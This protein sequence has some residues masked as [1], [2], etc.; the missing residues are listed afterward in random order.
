VQ[1]ALN[2]LETN[3]DTQVSMSRVTGAIHALAMNPANPKLSD[4]RVRQ[5]LALAVDRQTM[6]DVVYGGYARA[7]GMIP[8][9][10]PFESEPS[11]DQLGS[12]M[13]FDP[14][15]AKKLLSAA[16]AENLQLEDRH[17]NY[18][19]S[20]GSVGEVLVQQFADIGVT[21][22]L[23]ADDYNTYTTLW[24]GGNLEEVTH[25][26]WGGG[27][28]TADG[29]TYVQVHT[30]SPGNRWKI[31]DSV[32]DDLTLRQRVEHDPDARRELL[33]QIY[34]HDMDK[35]YRLPMPAGH[36]IESMQP[37]VRRMRFGGAVGTSA[38]N[39]DWAEQLNSIWLDK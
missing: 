28:P 18:L 11:G 37:W 9:V 3:P 25:T 19:A 39:H 2:L 22:D 34:D 5:G 15:E 38:G 36:S 17:F 20:W 7:H 24:V 14:D 29:Y 16:G 30:E 6:I 35:M 12:Y 8:W 31:S 33:K 13:H 23:V 1:D 4:D 27:G 10:F 21:M 32:F 26:A